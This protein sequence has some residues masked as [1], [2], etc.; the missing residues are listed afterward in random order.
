MKPDTTAVYSLTADRLEPC[1]IVPVPFPSV[2]LTDA[3]EY[4][5]ECQYH[6]FRVPSEALALSVCRA[7]ARG[8][9]EAYA[10]YVVRF[11]VVEPEE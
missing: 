3:G 7:Y 5:V 2:Y 8:N 10:A 9:E 1:H 11:G 4:L 6:I